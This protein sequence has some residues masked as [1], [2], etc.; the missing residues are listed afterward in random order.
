MKA[1]TTVTHRWLAATL[2]RGNLHELSR[3]IS[4]WNRQPD[5]VLAKKLQL[6]PNP[7]A[8]PFSVESLKEAR[9]RH[10]PRAMAERS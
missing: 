1:R 3:K 7:N 9:R 10:G 5:P 4:T 2:H 6:T 8:D